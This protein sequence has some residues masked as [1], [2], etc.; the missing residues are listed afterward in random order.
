[1]RGGD[2]ED[3]L[4]VPAG[5]AAAQIGSRAVN[6]GGWAS[7]WARLLIQTRSL[8]AVCMCAALSL[9][10]L[11]GCGGG[12]YTREASVWE[13]CCWCSG[14][15]EMSCTAVIYE[16]GRVVV[17]GTRHGAKNAAV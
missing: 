12:P 6:M 13:A 3:C 1:M 14:V 16:I 15:K 8:R 7:L 10:K 4:V 9:F 11:R 2:R 5:L 17:G